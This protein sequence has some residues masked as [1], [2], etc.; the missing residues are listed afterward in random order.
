LNPTPGN[1]IYEIQNFRSPDGALQ[2][3]LVP[4]GYGAP[5]VDGVPRG[6]VQTR[7][8]FTPPWA[9]GPRACF[10]AEG[11]L[12]PY[13]VLLSTLL[14]PARNVAVQGRLRASWQRVA[15]PGAPAPEP[16]Q[17]LVLRRPRGS[18]GRGSCE[19]TRR[20]NV[21]GAARLTI[22]SKACAPDSVIWETGPKERSGWERPPPDVW[23]CPACAR[24]KK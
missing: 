14:L 3:M 24:A 10:S 4:K 20:H 17:N 15:N 6:G 1:S 8:L 13:H 22:C 11:P 16:R 7:G 21:S 9:K 18:N 19:Q 12:C 2:A 5:Q 23:N